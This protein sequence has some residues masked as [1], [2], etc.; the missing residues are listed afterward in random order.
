MGMNPPLPPHVHVWNCIPASSS[1]SLQSAKLPEYNHNKTWCI[2]VGKNW[3]GIWRKVNF[4]HKE[5]V[6]TEVGGKNPL[7]SES[8]P[9]KLPCARAQ[10]WNQPDPIDS[11][12]LA[13]LQV[14]AI[15]NLGEIWRGLW[16]RRERRKKKMSKKVILSAQQSGKAGVF[17]DQLLTRLMVI[18]LHRHRFTVKGPS[19]HGLSL[20]FFFFFY[21]LLFSV[22]LCSLHLPSLRLPYLLLLHIISVFPRYRCVF[23]LIILP[24][25]QMQLFRIHPDQTAHFLGHISELLSH[26]TILITYSLTHTHTDR[27]YTNLNHI[28]L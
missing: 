9:Q 24:S 17:S 7:S 12:Y 18:F 22:R 10:P 11:V 2:I 23:W 6:W 15:G 21:S 1:G 20:S 26:G 16:I 8:G 28:E 27:T 13:R 5:R 19:L 3:V 4:K 25:H 14:K